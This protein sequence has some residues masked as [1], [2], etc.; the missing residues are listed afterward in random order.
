MDWRE[1]FEQ[2][3]SQVL[4]MQE[5]LRR[6]S[7]WMLE[8]EPDAW[9]FFDLAKAVDPQVRADED[10]IRRFSEDPDSRMGWYEER[11]GAW[12]LHFEALLDAGVVLP[13]LP[14]PYEPLILMFERGS[15]I[16]IDEIGRID[17][18]FVQM[19]R[20]WP[21]NYR[22]QEPFAPMGHKLLD[23]LEW[24]LLLRALTGVLSDLGAHSELEISVPGLEG[25]PGVHFIR[26]DDEL[27][28]DVEAGNRSVEDP[29]GESLGHQRM[30]TALPA[31]NERFHALAE[32]AVNA[33]RDRL[34]IADPALLRYSAWRQVGGAR[35]YL[36]NLWVKPDPST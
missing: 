27:I 13:D 30:M 12:A 21:R 3:Q 26:T 31:S 5:Y 10:V 20:A 28:V 15:Q 18:D 22:V 36:P 11:I 23:I 35:I 29:A 9:P 33:L 16:S 19:P 34:R 25:R 7:W 24:E 4:L 14:N 6:A 17:V 8:F 32:M 1:M 2:R